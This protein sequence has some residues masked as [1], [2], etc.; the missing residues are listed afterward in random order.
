MDNGPAI[1]CR[2]RIINEDLS[3]GRREVEN[4]DDVEVFNTVTHS[5]SNCGDGHGST[6]PY[7]DGASIKISTGN[8]LPAYY[9]SSL[10]D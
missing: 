10:W 5:L 8:E 9:P 6:G 1:H 7:V 2:Y 3:R 4:D